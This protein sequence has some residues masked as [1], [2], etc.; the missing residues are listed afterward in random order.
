MKEQ[1]FMQLLG[2]LIRLH[3]KKAGMKQSDLA[4]AIGRSVAS[5]SKYERG[6]C[7]IDSYTLANIADALHIG[8]T[9]LLPDTGMSDRVDADDQRWSILTRHD[10]FYLHNIGYI[11]QQLCCSLIKVD[12]AVNEAVMYVDMGMPAKRIDLHAESTLRG[13]IY[14]TSA[15][16]NIWVNNPIAPIDFYHIVINSADWYAG[17]QICHIHYSTANWRS[18]ASKGVITTS[19]E[20]PDD[21]HELLAFSREELR[22]IKKKNQVLF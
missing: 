14:S 13:R 1:D 20:C 17:K 21:I 5:V 16:T 15:S 18:I 2:S 4:R 12:W 11:S 10:T 7:A 3:R 9:Q 22:E 8:V 19:P 6:D